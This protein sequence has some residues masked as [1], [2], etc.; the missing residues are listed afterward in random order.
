M[1]IVTVQYVGKRLYLDPDPNP[2]PK[3]QIISGPSGSGST[4]L[5]NI[6]RSPSIRLLCDLKLAAPV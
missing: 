4:T 3:M 6:N 5:Q 2:D 1:L